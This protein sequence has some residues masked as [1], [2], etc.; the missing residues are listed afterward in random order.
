MVVKSGVYDWI[1]L[2]LFPKAKPLDGCFF[3]YS[4]SAMIE[5]S[6]TNGLRAFDLA[7]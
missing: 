4:S 5:F 7:T 3:M 6:S 2:L 1:V